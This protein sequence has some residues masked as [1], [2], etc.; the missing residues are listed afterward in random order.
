MERKVLL[1]IRERI[2][3]LRK[4]NTFL[5]ALPQFMTEKGK[6]NEIL[7]PCAQATGFTRAPYS[8]FI[9]SI[10]MGHSM[11]H[12][13]CA[14]YI[15]IQSLDRHITVLS[16]LTLSRKCWYH[17]GQSFSRLLIQVLRQTGSRRPGDFCFLLVTLFLL[18]VYVHLICMHV[19]M[20]VHMYGGTYMYTCAH[21]HTC[22][23]C[24]LISSMFFTCSPLYLLR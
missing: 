19:Y 7:S 14:S 3:E 11:K 4:S 20:H 13:P 17:E 8:P 5:P 6:E 2:R 23:Y 12:L 16:N 18:L 1:M 22:L 15:N 21:A 24:K 9:L 10:V